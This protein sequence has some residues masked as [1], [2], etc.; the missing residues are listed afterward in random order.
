MNKEQLQEKVKDMNAYLQT[1]SSDEPAAM[2]EKMEL[3]EIMIA[4]A[5]EYLALSKSYQDEII[6]QTI[7][8]HDV[9]DDLSASTLNM[10]IKASAKDWNYLV[11]S[12]DRIN[13]AAV[14]QHDGLRTRISYI[15]TL[16][17]G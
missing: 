2:L 17:N 15:K 1:R 9:N 7:L 16:M 3:L 5:G 10:F 12:F 11:T 13:A 8:E 14:H 6:Q 4:Q